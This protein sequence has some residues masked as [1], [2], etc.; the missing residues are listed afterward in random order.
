MNKLYNLDMYRV[1]GTELRP[2]EGEGAPNTPAQSM[3]AWW[4][5]QASRRMLAACRS[6]PA[7]K[8]GSRAWL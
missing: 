7:Q 2:L 4:M 1:A 8:V 3:R 6:T 5:P